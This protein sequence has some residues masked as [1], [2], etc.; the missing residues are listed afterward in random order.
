VWAT[1][2]DRASAIIYAN[3][4]D[5]YAFHPSLF[6]GCDPYIKKWMNLRERKPAKALAG[7]GLE[8]LWAFEKRAKIRLKRCHDSGARLDGLR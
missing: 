6:K 4:D 2:T 7:S 8:G 5:T 1:R 3:W